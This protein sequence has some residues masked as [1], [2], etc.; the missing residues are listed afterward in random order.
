MKK[1]EDLAD[2]RFV[3]AP[4]PSVETTAA[5]P[6]NELRQK[7][8]GRTLPEWLES[9]PRAFLGLFTIL[10]FVAMT[11]EHSRMGFWIDELFTCYLA[12]L[13]SIRDIWPLIEKGIELN[14]PLTFWVTWWLHHTI[15]QGEVISRLPAT[16]GF[17]VMCVCLYHFV[18]RRSDVLH[19]FL[20]L[21]L[22][23]F[24]YTSSDATSARGYGMLLG[25]SGLLLL[26]WQMA[27]DGER[28]RASVAGIA[29]AACGVIS[30][31]YYGLY[32]IG[33]VALGE[34]IRTIDRRRLDWA[35]GAALLLGC[36]PLAF[37]LPLVRR[38]KQGLATFWADP[39]G[40]FIYQS[41]ADLLGPVSVVLLLFVLT[42]VA[43]QQLNL[44]RWMPQTLKRHEVAMCGAL[45]LMPAVIYLAALAEVAAFYPRYV[46]PVV[47]GFTIMTVLFA[48]RIGGANAWFRSTSIGVVMW[49]CLTPW[50]AW[51][52]VKVLFPVN[53]GAPFLNKINTAIEPELP[54]IID[55]DSDYMSVYH[56]ATPALR[57][58]LFMLNDA[59]AAV[60]YRGSDTGMRSLEVGQTFRD[61]HVVD[62]RQFV[63]EHREFLVVR[64]RPTSWI[65]QSLMAD[66]AKVELINYHKDRR[67]FT[68]EAMLFKI[69]V[70]ENP[71]LLGP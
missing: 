7:R 68:E 66:G 28:R 17:W 6:A 39:A 26:C 37:Y 9:Y 46:Q 24:T 40:D 60:R 67:T 32:V 63:R 16:I 49:L 64:T 27:A 15:G 21:L 13:P 30:C 47:L 12:D 58:R 4:H 53:P 22:P 59:A 3:I 52:S 43:N 20:A 69:R 18:R 62:Y 1:D 10:Y 51:K 42:V 31:H 55:S 8:R 23:L 2:R 61:L 56:Y 70:R 54:L 65:V 41:Y 38:A 25:F 50:F 71:A 14:P 35:I 36:G 44:A 19:G 45:L 48:Y 33:A 34:V 29:L 57:K 5:A 11:A